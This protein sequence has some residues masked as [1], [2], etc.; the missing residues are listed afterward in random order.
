[1]D[2]SARVDEV[3]EVIVTEPDPD[4]LLGL[5][6]RLILG[7]LSVVGTNSGRRLRGHRPRARSGLALGLE[8]PAYSRPAVGVGHNFQPIRTIYAPDLLTIEVRMLERLLGSGQGCW[9]RARG[10]G[11]QEVRDADA[12]QKPKRPRRAVRSAVLASGP[13][14]QVASRL[15]RAV[16]PLAFPAPRCLAAHRCC[17]P[18][19]GSTAGPPGACRRPGR[20]AGQAWPRP[21]RLCV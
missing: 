3:C 1:M 16:S 18:R 4:W 20:C 19:C 13:D 2:T 17:W 14:P 8:P 7:R 21:A 6:P 5:S 11:R 12:P 15:A 10:A 9:V